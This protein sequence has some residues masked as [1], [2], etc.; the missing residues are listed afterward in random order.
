MLQQVNPVCVVVAGDNPQGAHRPVKA[1]ALS[2]VP[3]VGVAALL[4][5][6]TAIRSIRRFA[7]NPIT[8]FLTSDAERIAQTKSELYCPFKSPG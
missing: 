3:R 5:P 4:E 7:L 1:K 6:D 2:N 8:L